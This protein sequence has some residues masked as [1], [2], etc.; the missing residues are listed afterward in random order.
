MIE[1][2]KKKKPSKKTRKFDIVID[3]ANI[4][5]YK[6]NF[7]NAPKHVDYQQIDWVVQHFIND[8]KKILL[9]L[10]Q[11]HFS[12]SLMPL[13]AKPIIQGWEDANILYRSP[14][15]SNDDWFWMHAALWCGR[16]TYV[17]SNDLMRDHQFQMLAH[18]SFS[19]WKERHRVGFDFGGWIGKRRE[20][21]LV[22]P[23]VYSRRIQRLGNYGL[24][25]PL[26][27]R[28]DENRFLDGCHTAGNNAPEN[29]TYV[30]IRHPIF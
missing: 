27:K 28:G 17:V 23:D 2:W 22:F 26:P 7:N 13:W 12:P 3:G 8:G 4:G 9:V 21:K 18:R 15:G 11:R 10:H 30:C 24:I 25:V 1:L 16:D 20:V 6:K 14:V 29:E 19:R 5:Y